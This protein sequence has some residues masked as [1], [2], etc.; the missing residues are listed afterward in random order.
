MNY[1]VLSLHEKAEW[2][3]Y[4]SKIHLEEKDIYFTPEYYEIYEKNGEGIAHCFIYENSKD[5]ALYPFLVNPIKVLGYTLEDEYFD[6]QSVYGYNGILTNSFSSNFIEEFYKSFNAYC[7]EN[8]IIAEFIRFHP[9]FNNYRFSINH[10]QVIFD[11]KT[12]ALDLTQTYED[13]WQ[14]E[15]TSNNRNMIRKAEKKGYS[16]EVIS[17]PTKDQID[18]FSTIY[19]NSMNM[20]GADDYYLFN[21]DFFYNTYK[22]LNNYA[23]LFNIVDVNN[24]ITSSAI[25]FHFGDFFHYHL[26]GRTEMANNS[27]NNLL[28]DEAV[29]FAKEKGAKIFHLGGGRSSL[30]D[31]S[32]LKFKSNFSKTKL[33]FYIGKKIHNQQVYDEVIKQWE[34]KH[35]EKKE[36]YKNYLLK[37]RY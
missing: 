33:D 23:Y 26:S 12:V 21:K 3:E 32:L 7:L 2:N 1:K 36:K 14:K 34:E 13:I 19:L 24:E 15:Y 30:P 18:K 17:S 25:F 20:V 31:D 9:I 35:P 10:I 22:Y 5:V 8:N 28:L 6:I 4:L 11:R 16:C 27:V 37:Y 29:K